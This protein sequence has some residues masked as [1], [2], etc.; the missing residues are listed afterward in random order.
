MSKLNK[1]AKKHQLTRTE[2]IKI[3][4]DSEAKSERY[5]NER[6]DRVKDLI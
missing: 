2:I 5:I 4:I 3:L 1:L 6:I